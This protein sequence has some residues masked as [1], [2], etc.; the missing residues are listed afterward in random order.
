M[1]R[2]KKQRSVLGMYTEASITKEF[3]NDSNDSKTNNAWRYTV[4]NSDNTLT[5][6]VYAH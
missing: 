2:G 4:P 5:K 1:Q 3:L 6:N